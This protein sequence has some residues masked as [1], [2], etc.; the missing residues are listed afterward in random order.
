MGVQSSHSSFQRS[1]RERLQRQGLL[2]ENNKEWILLTI[3]LL[4]ASLILSTFASESPLTL[5][6]ALLVVICIPLT[7]QMPTDF[8]FLMSATFCKSK[9]GCSRLIKCQPESLP[10][11]VMCFCVRLLPPRCQFYTSSQ[12]EPTHHV[13]KCSG[14]I[15][16]EHTQHAAKCSGCALISQEC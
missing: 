5:H 3:S 16:V 6:R 14:N 2:S 4:A 1:Q 15:R 8:S 9:N 11:Y 7:V 10:Y 13:A 12:V